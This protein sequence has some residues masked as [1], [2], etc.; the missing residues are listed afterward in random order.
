MLEELSA[1]FVF[2]C[3]FTMSRL[4]FRL[5]V[6]DDAGRVVRQM[7]IRPPSAAM[8]APVM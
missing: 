6:G 4:P 5:A 7:A 8:T 2:S 3:S 1:T